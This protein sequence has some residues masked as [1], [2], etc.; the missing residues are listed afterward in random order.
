MHFSKTYSQLL[1]TLPKELRNSAIEYGQLKKII[2]ELVAELESLGLSPL[3]LQELLQEQDSYENSKR[4]IFRQR[5]G[6]ERASDETP[7]ELEAGFQRLLTVSLPAPLSHSSPAK[8]VYEFTDEGG[9]GDVVPRLRLWVEESGSPGSALLV[10]EDLDESDDADDS[11]VHSLSSSDES[12]SVLSVK[13]DSQPPEAISAQHGYADDDIVI[14]SPVTP[15]PRHDLLWNLQGRPLLKSRDSWNTTADSNLPWPTEHEV[16][17]P[18]T[19]N[20]DNSHEVVIPLASDTAFFRL[21]TNALE[22]L[23]TALKTSQEDFESSI[24][25]L[26]ATIA[27]TSRPASAGGKSDLYTWRAI[28]Q[29]YMEAQVFESTSERDRGQ[30]SIK[31]SEARLAQFAHRVGEGGFS[32]K[33]ATSRNGLE[34]FLQLNVRLMNLKKFQSANTDA[35]RKILKKHAKRTALPLPHSALELIPVLELG[36]ATA[37]VPHLL[38]VALTETLM[39]IVP[40]IDDYLCSI[41]MVI[42]F[43]PIRLHCGH[44]FC[45]RCLVKMQKRGKDNCPMCR[46]PTV[47]SADRSNVDHALINFMRDWFPKETKVKGKANEEEAAQEEMEE[48]GI[49]P[50]CQVM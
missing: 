8:A 26:A 21:L 39:P 35:A 24:Q 1:L 7:A 15:H 48:L 10:A 20:R 6:K 16:I 40:H 38:V 36:K 2:N 14:S 32:F 46:A 37:S 34:R 42:A 9:S 45:V 47:L 50:R 3:V 25:E 41:C 28:F 19:E 49:D 31:D 43:K 29:L 22:S 30:R 4:A 33:M 12:R 17:I 11:F 27:R 23:S 13:T 18:T 5:K 44:L